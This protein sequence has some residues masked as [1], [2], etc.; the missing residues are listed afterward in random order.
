MMPSDV[1]ASFRG[2][3]LG[4]VST[5]YQID[6]GLPRTTNVVHS[7]NAFVD[8]S[9]IT[10]SN[11]S[12][13]FIIN[14]GSVP[15]GVTVECGWIMP[16]S[17]RLSKSGCDTEI[18]PTRMISCRCYHLTDFVLIITGPDNIIFAKT[19]PSADNALSWILPLASMLNVGLSIL[20]LLLGKP[21]S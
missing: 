18:S 1:I 13:P 2:R 5:V 10:I 6:S 17:G 8:N 20:Q 11:A 3:A 15:S 9:P 19:T 12:S 4:I 21:K 16:D 14:M 7:V